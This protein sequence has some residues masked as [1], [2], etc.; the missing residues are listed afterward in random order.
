MNI[1]NKTNVI[2]VNCAL[3]LRDNP[4]LN[5]LKGPTIFVYCLTPN[6]FVEKAKY[7][8]IPLVGPNKFK[9]M[10][11]CISR[12]RQELKDKFQCDL[13]VLE[14]TYLQ[15]VE[16][17]IEYFINVEVRLL[18]Q[19]F[20]YEKS[21]ERQLVN[22]KYN[23]LNNTVKVIK[24]GSTLIP[25]D[26]LISIYKGN[27]GGTFHSFFTACLQEQKNIKWWPDLDCNNIS[28][29][30]VN[31][32]SIDGE[33]DNLGLLYDLDNLVGYADNKNYISGKSTTKLEAAISFGTV[34][35]TACYGICL[36][37]TEASNE[38][39]KQ[40]I[41]SLIWNDY[42]YSIAEV[43]ANKIF[44]KDGLSKDLNRGKLELVPDFIRG[45]GTEVKFYNKAMSNL[46][47]EGYL[48][49]RVRMMIGSYLIKVMGYSHLA[50]AN[51]FEYH[52]VANS[53]HNNWLGAQS[54]NGTGV[55]TVLGGRSFNI[56]KQLKMYD[57][58]KE[59]I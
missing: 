5:E 6:Y 31:I 1:P 28:N 13:L 8:D 20:S 48:P 18:H 52:L 25:F 35:K 39:K 30:S 7:T 22:S 19:P 50:V 51:Y 59:Y 57:L 54:C 56:K 21:Y 49:N 15:V 47:K 37:N 40:F 36:N 58:N 4:L 46:R 33:G 32:Q 17:L 3:R 26:A 34:S 45:T 14:G 43:E 9:Y 42:C 2:I 55:D 29:V 12:F 44:L 24:E 38:D 27:K 11:S 41:R 10:F 53:I 16:Q 23:K